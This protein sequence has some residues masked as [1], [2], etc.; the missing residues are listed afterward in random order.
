MRS[1]WVDPYLWIHLV[2]IAAVPIFLEFCLLG[3]SLGEPLFPVWFELLFVGTIGILPILWMQWQRPFSI[4]SLLVLALKPTHLTEDQRRILALFKAPLNRVLAVLVT[5]GMTWGL[6]QLY[7]LAPAVSPNL[8]PGIARGTALLIAALAFFGANLFLQIPI[9]VLGV[10]WTSNS[11]FAATTPYPVEHIRQ[12]FTIPGIRVGAIVPPLFSEPVQATVSTSPPPP[13]VAPLSSTPSATASVSTSSP[14]ALEE[15]DFEDEEFNTGVED[16]IEPSDVDVNVSDTTPNAEL[17]APADISPT[18]E[19]VDADA[20]IAAELVTDAA[21]A[22]SVDAIETT[23]LE[24]ARDTIEIEPTLDA[25]E[26]AESS[27]DVT[28]SAGTVTDESGVE[29][30]PSFDST[31][32]EPPVPDPSIP[33]TLLRESE[34]LRLTE[35][36]D[37]AEEI[38]IAESVVERLVSPEGLQEDAMIT[39]TTGGASEF[40]PGFDPNFDDSTFAQEFQPEQSDAIDRTLDPEDSVTSS[41]GNRAESID[42]PPDLVEDATLSETIEGHDEEEIADR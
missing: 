20:P 8:F 1:F 37:V 25:N 17:S 29:R 23:D 5:V 31:Q 12:S 9:S 38:P 22:D 19:F 32:A 6:W 10:L 24:T 40:D 33:T 21:I 14:A 36:A 2:G 4:F 13:T 34:P 11:Q 26:T 42:P 35:S 3:L 28:A 18:D 27:D 30:P 41:A 15:D 7:Q 39:E 16:A